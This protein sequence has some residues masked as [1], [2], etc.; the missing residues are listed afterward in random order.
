[1]GV[2][3]L[4]SLDLLDAWE[5]EA[6]RPIPYRGLELLTTAHG[7]APDPRTTTIGSR[8]A[9][10]CELRAATFG[11]DLVGLAT[12]P[13]CR[14]DLELTGSMRD[15]MT[16]AAPAGAETVTSAFDGYQVSARLPTIADLSRGTQR[17]ADVRDARRRLLDMI[18]IEAAHDG[19]PVPID[20]LPAQ[21]LDDLEDQLAAADQSADT[22]F[23]LRC[24]DCG[25]EWAETFDIAAF[26]WTELNSW[27]VRTLEDV[28]QLAA[29]YGWP[30]HVILD[31]AERRRRI[32]LELINT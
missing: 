21:V 32:Y 6:E 11:D 16:A 29:A 12:C 18:I 25:A 28:H 15:L 8:D 19:R 7:F 24:P 13:G 31:M 9:Q 17:A 26:F 22:Q 3:A 14:R 27:A 30:E 20:E 2:A 23:A 1:M 4:S 10:L 5:R